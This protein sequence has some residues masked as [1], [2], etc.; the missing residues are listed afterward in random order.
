MDA[1]GASNVAVP[2]AVLNDTTSIRRKG[3]RKGER[4]GR[5]ARSQRRFSGLA[6]A[7]HC[8]LG[9]RPAKALFKNVAHAL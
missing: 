8:D 2:D 5:A 4:E 6:A 3:E 7:M 9:L 1:L